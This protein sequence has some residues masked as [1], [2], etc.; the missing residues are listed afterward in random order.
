MKDLYPSFNISSEAISIQSLNSTFERLKKS[1]VFRVRFPERKKTFLTRF[2]LDNWHKL[3]KS[4]P[5]SLFHCHACYKF[6]T[7][8]SVLYLFTNLSNKYKSQGKK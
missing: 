2:S 5:Y 1:A 7:L 3:D 4:K 8:K 6:V